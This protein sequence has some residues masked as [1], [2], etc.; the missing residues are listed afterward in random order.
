MLESKQ[1][2]RLTYRVDKRGIQITVKPSADPNVLE[3]IQRYALLGKD[4]VSSDEVKSIKAVFEKVRDSRK[5]ISEFK[6]DEEISTGSM[7]F[8]IFEGSTRIGKTQTFWS[9]QHG[10]DIPHLYV[11]F[12]ERGQTQTM[13]D[14]FFSHSNALKKCLEADIEELLTKPTSLDNPHQDFEVPSLRKTTGEFRTLGYLRGLLQSVSAA[15]TK[16][17][18]WLTT[19]ARETYNYLGQKCSVDD[20]WK[21]GE[22]VIGFDEVQILSAA[23]L[24]LLRNLVRAAGGVAVMMG[25]SSSICN[26]ISGGSDKMSRASLS[27]HFPWCHLITKYPPI[28]RNSLL[29]RQC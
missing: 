15:K 19:Q 27:V 16:T 28:T 1:L 2:G 3:E 9:V 13:H 11:P 24:Q 20:M 26:I 12:A 17:T 6:A 8:V 18:D 25:T 10:S 21:A 5:E 23:H 4:L 7:P 29:I 22:F 14:G